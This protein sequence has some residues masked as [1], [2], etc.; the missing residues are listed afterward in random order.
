[1]T[2][3]EAQKLRKK[4]S[5]LSQNI[6]E[7]TER[8]QKSP[9]ESSFPL[10][11]SAHFSLFNPKFLIRSTHALSSPAP[12]AFMFFPF[13]AQCQNTSPNTKKNPNE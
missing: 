7:N 8:I 12:T 1:M 13:S 3:N 2:L 4:P 5:I 10:S 11:F 9:L 6:I